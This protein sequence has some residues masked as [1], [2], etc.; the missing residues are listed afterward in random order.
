MRVPHTDEGEMFG[1][2]E[3]MYGGSRLQVKC[4]DGKERIVRIPG[5]IRR[6]IWVRAGDVVIL[7]PWK[8]DPDHRADLAWRYTRVQADML[9]HRGILKD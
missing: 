8:I 3:S 9:R 7:V 5:K 6:N 1:L 4:Q 2:V